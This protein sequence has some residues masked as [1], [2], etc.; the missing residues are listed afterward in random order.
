MTSTGSGAL[1]QLEPAVPEEGS[2]L[3]VCFFPFSCSEE[4]RGRYQVLQGL[5]KVYQWCLTLS[6]PMQCRDGSNAGGSQLGRGTS[7]VLLGLRLTM[8][9]QALPF[10]A[11]PAPIY[12]Q[13]LPSASFLE[14]VLYFGTA[15]LIS[16]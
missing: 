15:S 8:W 11:P 6:A 14:H 2:D 10:S 3:G 4:R 5:G 13:P 1:Q 16:R 7:T 12:V 9:L